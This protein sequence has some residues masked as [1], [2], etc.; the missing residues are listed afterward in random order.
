MEKAFKKNFDA[1]SYALKEIKVAKMQ[2]TGGIISESRSSYELSVERN[3]ALARF[4]VSAVAITLE[5]G[6]SEKTYLVVMNT[7]TLKKK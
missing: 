3:G 7:I 6:G 2:K 1:P 5:S 4:G